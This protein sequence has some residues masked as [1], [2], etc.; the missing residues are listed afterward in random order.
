MWSTESSGSYRTS[1][2]LS[3]HVPLVCASFRTT[4]RT[5][6]TTA[7]YAALCNCSRVCS[8]YCTNIR[9][10]HRRRAQWIEFEGQSG[11]LGVRSPRGIHYY[12]FLSSRAHRMRCCVAA[13]RRR[14][15]GR[16]RRYRIRPNGTPLHTA[17]DPARQATTTRGRVDKC[18]SIHSPTTST[19]MTTIEDECVPR[20]TRHCECTPPR[21]EKERESERRGTHAGAC[22]F[23]PA[24]ST[25]TYA[26]WSRRRTRT[27]QVH[28]GYITLEHPR[29]HTHNIQNM[30]LFVIT[31]AL[32]PER[33]R[34]RL[35]GANQPTQRAWN[36]RA[37]DDASVAVNGFGDG[38]GAPRERVSA[39]ATR[40]AARYRFL[41]P[42]GVSAAAASV[43]CRCVQ[44][45]CMAFSGSAKNSSLG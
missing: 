2:S 35:A 29:T 32:A 43:M 36:D 9:H 21:T 31:H 5:T 23:L 11:L 38:A 34:R 40:Q 8:L 26:R 16:R 7:K 3:S 33:Q 27:L 14:R 15:R 4:T 6:T 18:H 17:V 39:R 45:W 22:V 37:S 12:T 44:P 13:S 20:T 19:T 24:S 1:G 41:R 10:T 28:P 30:S 25:C 42:P